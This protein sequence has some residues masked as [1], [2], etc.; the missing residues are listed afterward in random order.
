MYNCNKHLFPFSSYDF[1]DLCRKSFKWMPRRW[2]DGHRVFYYENDADSSRRILMPLIIHSKELYLFSDLAGVGPRDFLYSS[3]VTDEDFLIFFENLKDIFGNMHMFFGVL[4]DESLFNKFLCGTYGR[5]LVIN[6]K[7]SI[8]V[9]ISFGDNY[10][11]YYSKLS[12]NGRGNTRRMYNRLK[13]EKVKWEF[14]VA[15]TAEQRRKYFEP[16]INC[17]YERQNKVYGQHF[18]WLKR[19]YANNILASIVGIK[20]LGTARIFCLKIN[21]ELAAV[22]TGY[23]ANN[24]S[25][26]VPRGAMN[27]EYKHYSVGR[28]LIDQ[29]IRYFIDK[30]DVRCLDLTFGDEPYKFDVGGKPY[31]CHSYEIRLR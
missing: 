25:F 6:R 19:K 28:V 30:T 29:M 3:N 21:G 10:E 5:N 7:D 22:E 17:W 12:Q 1:F 2:F 13:R 9:K 15:E 26:L 4:R 18:C 24:H 20:E 23:L 14:V 11:E 27:S 8:A 16:A 31:C